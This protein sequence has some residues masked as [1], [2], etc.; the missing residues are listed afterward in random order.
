MGR[1][2][3]DNSEKWTVEIIEAF[4]PNFYTKDR[5]FRMA[6]EDFFRYF[7]AVTVCKVDN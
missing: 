1:A 7:T 3:S 2:W 6:Y 4:Q 5:S